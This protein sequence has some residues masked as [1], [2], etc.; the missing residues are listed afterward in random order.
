ME[1]ANGSEDMILYRVEAKR[2]TLLPSAFSLLGI[3]SEFVYRE[4]RQTWSEVMRPLSVLPL[5]E[6]QGPCY[7]QEKEGEGGAPRPPF[8]FYVSFTT[9]DFYNW[10]TADPRFS[11]KLLALISLLETAF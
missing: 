11:E 3:Q 5:K 9:R 7:R 6:A 4:A 8:M 10:K 2:P 1:N